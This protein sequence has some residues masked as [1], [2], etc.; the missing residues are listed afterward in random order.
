MNS[1]PKRTR[2]VFLEPPS[3]GLLSSVVAKVP[4]L[5]SGSCSLCLAF[6]VQIGL[7]VVFAVDVST[8]N[9]VSH[10]PRNGP[11]MRA[12]GGFLLAAFYRQFH[13]V[14]RTDGDALPNSVGKGATTLPP[15]PKAQK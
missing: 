10:P 12:P 5:A 15:T 7:V 14:G 3:T 1:H 6:Q 8:T 11:A 2:T 13:P 4:R 9:T